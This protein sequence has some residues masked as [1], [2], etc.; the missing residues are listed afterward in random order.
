METQLSKDKKKK[1]K[2]IRV[3]IST[4]SS[5]GWRLLKQRVLQHV[6]VNSGTQILQCC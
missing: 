1:K 2:A 5:F 4:Q 6:A 3:F